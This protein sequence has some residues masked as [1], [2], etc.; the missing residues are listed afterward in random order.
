MSIDSFFHYGY[1]DDI[2]LQDHM[3]KY[4]KGEGQRLQVKVMIDSLVQA[5]QMDHDIHTAMNN[6]CISAYKK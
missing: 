5:Q 4:Y 3:I 2:D 1:V 6:K